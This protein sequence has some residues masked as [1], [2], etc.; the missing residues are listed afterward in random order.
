MK[1]AII[2]CGS[3][4]GQGLY[5]IARQYNVNGNN[6]EIHAFEA[7]PETFKRLDQNIKNNN[8]LSDY[9]ENVNL[10]NKAVWVENCE[11]EITLE[12]CPFEKGWVGGATNIMENNYKKPDYLHDWQIE[13]G[14]KIECI[15]FSDFIK[16]S[17]DKDDY[18][19]CKMDIEGAEYEIIKDMQDKGVL[20]Y[21]N[22]LFVEWHNRLLHDKYDQ[23][24]IESLIASNNIEL[25]PWG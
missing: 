20:S 10:Y 22:V 12:Y 2:D 24:Y 9:C 21:I 7:N 14:N 16:K 15:D 23:N 5:N 13:K 4:L 11:K 17:F 18:I 25:K 3:N 6:W 19:V 8:W 1:K